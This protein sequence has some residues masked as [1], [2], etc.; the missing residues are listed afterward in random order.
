MYGCTSASPL[1]NLINEPYIYVHTDIYTRRGGGTQ[2]KRKR[3]KEREREPLSLGATRVSTS[4]IVFLAQSLAHFGLRLVC[5]DSAVHVLA[6]SRASAT[7]ISDS[8]LVF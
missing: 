4:K 1:I 6:H 2:R 8:G 3:E 7:C 5:P